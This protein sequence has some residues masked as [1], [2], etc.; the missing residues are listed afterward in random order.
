MLLLLLL[1]VVVVDECCVFFFSFLHW[2][3]STLPLFSQPLLA[4]GERQLAGRAAL[5]DC[6]HDHDGRHGCHGQRH[7]WRL[8]HRRAAERARVWRVL[9][10]HPT[11][12]GRSVRGSHPCAL[13]L[14][15]PR[16]RA[17]LCAS[18]LLECHPELSPMRPLTRTTAALCTRRISYGLGHVGANYKAT[19]V[20]RPVVLFFFPL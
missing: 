10:D 18:P 15:L 20:A 17:P 19:T 6:K 4:R 16:A 12:H 9:D 1:L 5:P 7:S 13:S 14:V 2:I 8:V 3:M 11:G